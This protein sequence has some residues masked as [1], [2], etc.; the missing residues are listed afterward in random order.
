[1]LGALLILL[2]VAS[3]VGEAERLA[4]EA[5]AGARGEPAAALEKGHRALA[6]TAD[7][8]PTAFV[9][10]GRKGEV[11]EDAY[12]AARQ[13]YRRHRARLYRAIGL[14]HAASGRA[15]EASRYLGRAVELDAA[16]EARPDL[17]S[18]LVEL[19]RGRDALDLLLA[20]ELAGPLDGLL[21][22]AGAA[23]DVAGVPSLQ[24][25]LD[26][27]RTA[28]ARV[29]PALAFRDGPFALTGRERL[30][31]GARL[32]L[33]TEAT[34]VFYLAE[35][36]CR[37]CSADLEALR[38]AVPQAMPVV[39]APEDPERDDVVRRAMRTYRYDWPL[40]VGP[41]L[42][43]TLG[44]PAPAA[45]VVGRRGFSAIVARPPL[46]ETLPTALA[47]LARADVREDLPRA[48]W[49]RAR[50]QPR[51]AAPPPG[52]LPEGLA[53]GEDAPQPEAFAA[54]IAAYREGRYRDALRGFE[55]I[56]ARGDGWLLSPEARLNR[57]LCLAGLGRRDEAR[58][59]L[60]KTGDSRF[61]EAVD[62]AME[63]VAAPPGGR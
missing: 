6:L 45:L 52:L 3:P 8:E 62:R 43:G 2:A 17:A 56:E 40:V 50:A 49:R 53:P 38:R 4:A 1:M 7:F 47:I 11:V 34:T 14:V 48:A 32:A 30:S 42:G 46:A 41:S 63:K 60:L 24:A 12:L 36:S 15:V 18:I 20:G 23:A 16:G 21:E 19:G 37:S 13:E 39:V 58:R 61:Q 57:A 44:L 5:I 51:P 9:T 33:D 26:R 25:E 59:L 27:V 22:V 35:A 31:T 54:A 10:A 29:E 28:A 55:E